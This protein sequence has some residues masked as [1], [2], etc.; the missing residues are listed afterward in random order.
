MNRY[1]L[2]THTIIW[3]L[4]DD[5]RLSD[6]AKK[7]IH[8]T[9]ALGSLIIPT[10]VLGEL[11]VVVEKGRVKGDLELLIKSIKNDPRFII[12]PFDIEAF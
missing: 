6:K 10:I 9:K 11:A 1:V 3:F 12:M 8:Q 2:D 4:L 7:I 5:R